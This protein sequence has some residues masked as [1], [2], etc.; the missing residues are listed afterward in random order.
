MSWSGKRI[1]VACL[2]TAVL[3]LML[4][5]PWHG[6]GHRLLWNGRGSLD[7]SRLTLEL[8][9]VAVTGALAAVVAP[10][11]V[12][13]PSARALKSWFRRVGL[14]L[15]CAAVLILAARAGYDRIIRIGLLRDYNQKVEDFKAKAPL[16]QEAFPLE[17]TRIRR[18]SAHGFP[19]YY[20]SNVHEAEFV[21]RRIGWEGSDIQRATAM[22]LSASVRE[23]YEPK[24]LSFL[25]NPEIA[26]SGAKGASFE[27]YIGDSDAAKRRFFAP[28]PDWYIE[29]L[30]HNIEVA[31]VPDWMK[32]GEPPAPWSLTE[33]LHSRSSWVIL[34][35]G[36]LASSVLCF[37]VASRIKRTRVIGG[38]SSVEP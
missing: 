31:S 22:F 21:L 23:S 1:I 7:W 13:R 16:L 25:S 28:L 6:R 2:L 17:S 5:P 20:I 18:L 3:G 4:C 35:A 30:Q 32:P 38:E 26:M 12:G 11:V 8:C 14:V 9:L 29:A 36:M 37:V 19:V 15:G 24:T 10:P 33:W 27:F 34:V